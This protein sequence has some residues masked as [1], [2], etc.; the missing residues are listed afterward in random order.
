[1]GRVEFSRVLPYKPPGR[2]CMAARRDELDGTKSLR[3]PCALT[4]ALQH[5]LP[6]PAGLSP[7]RPAGG[8]GGQGQPVVRLHAP[9]RRRP[10]AAP[11]DSAWPGVWSPSAHPKG[12]PSPGPSRLA[13]G[14]GARARPGPA[15][16]RGP[17][18]H[19]LSLR[20]PYIPSLG[21]NAAPPSA[22]AQ[23]EGGSCGLPPPSPVRGGGGGAPGLKHSGAGCL[24]PEDMDM[25]MGC[26]L[27]PTSTGGACLVF[28]PGW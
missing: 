10:R 12:S 23:V 7:P 16:G 13:G 18:M 28:P 26:D 17:T 20:L 5:S 2:V 6:S 22:P 19:P 14:G 21:H 24:L 9:C 27:G 11:T 4:G 3:L 15:A 8:S 25:V 1:M